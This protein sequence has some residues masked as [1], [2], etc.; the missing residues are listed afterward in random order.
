MVNTSLNSSS[1]KI[2]LHHKS[3]ID[4]FPAQSGVVPKTHQPIS[5][6]P[7]SAS[8]FSAALAVKYHLQMNFAWAPFR[9]CFYILDK[10][11]KETDEREG[12]TIASSCESE[13]FSA[14]GTWLVLCAILLSIT[15]WSPVYDLR[16]VLGRGGLLCFIHSRVELFLF[17]GGKE[18]GWISKQS[19]LK[20]HCN[21]YLAMIITSFFLHF[22]GLDL[23]KV[24][25]FEIYSKQFTFWYI[26]IVAIIYI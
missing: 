13:A 14:N 12:E 10:K 11:K 19:E 18:F 26:N 21:F 22:Q 5:I 9:E 23:T 1:K 17:L 8:I 3:T 2:T 7:M 6:A 16:V 4:P 24:A 25:L 15:T 20:S